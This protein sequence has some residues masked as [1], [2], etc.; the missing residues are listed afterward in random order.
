[1]NSYLDALYRNE[2]RK[3]LATLIRKFRDFELAE[4]FMHEA[5]AEALKRWA[6]DGIPEKPVPWLISTARFKAIDQLRRRKTF[7]RLLPELEREA[8]SAGAALDAAAD[9][10]IEDDR[11]RLI[12]TC[13]HPALPQ[14]AQ[15]ALTLREVCGI[16]TEEVARAL[17]GRTAA[18]AQRIVRAKQRIRKAQIP[19]EI[20]SR[21][22]M[23]ERLQSVLS[24]IYLLFNEAYSATSGE[25]IVRHD[26]AAEAIRLGRQLLGL[27]PHPEAAGLLALMVLQDSRRSARAD[28]E[29]G[30]VR[31][32][33]QDRSLWDAD[34]IAEGRALVTRALLTQR[35][36]AYTL[37]AAIAA[38]HAEAPSVEATDWHQI[39]GL[40]DAL[41]G[42]HDSPVIRLN[43]AVA[44]SM[45]D[46][47][48]AGL[49]LVESLLASGDLEDYY[50]C[51]AAA[52]DFHRQ[53]GNAREAAAA[54]E[55]A[56]ALTAQ[57]P[58]R[59]YL[60]QRLAEMADKI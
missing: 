50:L 42:L 39:V 38:V 21:E 55:R 18:V 45:R 3:I 40:Y 11:L 47:P 10:A 57:G 32:E 33:D 31:L 8:E 53:L 26:L 14:E 22:E 13:C 23:P 29:G 59:R 56:L 5:F 37:Q 24:V 36:G 27:L 15:L 30:L 51:H 54:Y 34:K 17:L 58:E 52:A 25:S 41:L 48:A 1:L 7:D 46:G 44:V 16:T 20:P 28:A 35:F 9:Q 2:S 4:E 19:Y 60:G 49:E 6:V 12:F 43:R